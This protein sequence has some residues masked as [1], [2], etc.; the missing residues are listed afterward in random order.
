MK[1]FYYINCGEELIKGIT[2]IYT[3][4]NYLCL[5]PVVLLIQRAEKYYIAELKN[6]SFDFA[7]EVAYIGPNTYIQF[8]Y[9][10]IIKRKGLSFNSYVGYTS[11]GKEFEIMQLLGEDKGKYVASVD[12]VDQ[13]EYK[14]FIIPSYFGEE[15]K[16]VNDFRR[17]GIILRKS[18]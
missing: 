7:N 13:N 8:A 4:V 17:Q 15:I 1:K 18:L 11:E 6:K 3:E 9:N 5:N 16:S 12:F 14:G 2:P 10:D